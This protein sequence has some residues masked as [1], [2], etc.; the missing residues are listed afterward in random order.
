VNQSEPD[1]HFSGSSRA[2]V[3]AAHLRL[4]VAPHL[5]VPPRDLSPQGGRRMRDEA[6]KR[7]KGASLARDF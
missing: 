3:L 6:F 1:A 2:N 5:S 7:A 4:N